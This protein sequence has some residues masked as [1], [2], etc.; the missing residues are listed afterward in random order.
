MKK[1]NKK[2]YFKKIRFLFFFVFYTVLF[3]FYPG[4]NDYF[5]IFADNRFLFLKNNKEYLK[6]KIEIPYV[7]N[8]HL[9]PNLS[10]EGIYVVELSS[11][12][13][14][15]KKNEKEKFFPASLTKII[16][17][18]VAFDIYSL[19]QVVK[20]KNPI[21][22][23]QIMGLVDE[24]KITVEN[25]LYGILIHSANDAA[26][27]LADNYGFNKFIALMNE[28]AKKLL[29][30]NTHFTNPAGFDNSSHFSA[31]YDIALAARALLNNSFLKK[32]V[33]LK[34]ITISDIDFKY[35]HH[36]VNVNQLLGEITGLGGIKT[37]FTE[38]A[39]E[40]LVSF[41]KKN[42]HQW[43]IVIVKSNNRFL[44]TREIINWIDN[45]ID[46]IESE[47]LF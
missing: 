20:I 12:T 30:N 42:H 13:P 36:L 33:S 25:L 1:K 47:R 10:A 15:Y 45:N 31:P 19:D 37:G 35:F 8:H 21:H 44:E 11:F 32:I 41:Y 22:K 18:L 23:G 3:L 17:A 14:V 4:S 5:H 2:T 38:E 43:L 39:G 40:N 16:T 34:E 28:K 29:M 26:Y 46:F 27:A 24:E 7:K 9:F 6:K